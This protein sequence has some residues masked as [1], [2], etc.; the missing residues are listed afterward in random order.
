MEFQTYVAGIPCICKVTHYARGQ[1]MIIHGSGF[2]DVHPPEPEE[3]E[4]ELLDLKGNPDPWLE[5]QID[6]TTEFLLKHEYLN[7]MQS[8]LQF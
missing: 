5:S 7:L 8:E 6:Y 1:A 2:G 4:Y 3:F